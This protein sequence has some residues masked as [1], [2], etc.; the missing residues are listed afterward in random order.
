MECAVIKVENYKPRIL[1]VGDM[2][3][4]KENYKNRIDLDEKNFFNENDWRRFNFLRHTSNFN[5][6]KED[7]A[8]YC[9]FA[10]RLGMPKPNRNSKIRPLH[11]QY[12]ESGNLINPDHI[13]K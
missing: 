4:L 2:Q 6:S 10:E 12:D 13:I 9:T 7:F 5:K 3:T 1:Q 11:E 8:E